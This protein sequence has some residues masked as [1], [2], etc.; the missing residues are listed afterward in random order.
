[1]AVVLV[2]LAMIGLK[3]FGS[4]VVLKISVPP[5]LPFSAPGDSRD[6]LEGHPT[7]RKRIR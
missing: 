6:F 5:Y 3:D 4:E 2:S 7:Q 1:M